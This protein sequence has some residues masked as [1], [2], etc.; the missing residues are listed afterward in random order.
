MAQLLRIRLQ[1]GRP[2]FDPWVGKIPWRRE[3]LPTPVFWPREFHGL[4]SPWGYKESDTTERLSHK[5]KNRKRT[6]VIIA[7]VL[8]IAYMND[9]VQG[10]FPSY[11]RVLGPYKILLLLT[12]ITSIFKFYIRKCKQRFR[13]LRRDLTWRGR[14]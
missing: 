9:V 7:P 6:R 4:C 8:Q 3:G 13:A 10:I 12:T 14:T 11:N 1:C 5:N 2:E